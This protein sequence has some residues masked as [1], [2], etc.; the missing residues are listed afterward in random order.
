M[1]LWKQLSIHLATCTFTVNQKVIIIVSLSC[2]FVKLIYKYI[3]LYFVDFGETIRG[4]WCCS[5]TIT[6]EQIC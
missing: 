5:K 1:L 2:S 6:V 4:C 3:L